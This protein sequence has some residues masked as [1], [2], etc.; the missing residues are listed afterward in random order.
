MSSFSN[1]TKVSKNGMSKCKSD[2]NPKL[3]FPKCR[4][5]Y[6]C[7][8]CNYY[9]V[10]KKSDVKSDETNRLAFEMYIGRSGFQ[11]HWKNHKNKL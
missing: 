6:H 3:C 10:S 1:L 9:T 7:K 4:Q 5:R 11:S 8:P 2:N